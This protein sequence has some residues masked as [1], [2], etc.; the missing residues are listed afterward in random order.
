MKL[1]LALLAS[2]AL[3]SAALAAPL[4]LSPVP[5][6]VMRQDGVAADTVLSEELSQKP[7]VAGAA[8]LENPTA[9]LSH[10]GYAADG[11]LAPAAGDTQSKDHNVEASKTEPDKNTYL[12]LEG[13]AGPDASYNYGTRFLFQG[14]E[15][16]AMVDGKPQGYIT[17]IN[18]DAD[19]AHR[20]TLMAD[21]DTAGNPLVFLDGSTWN[22]FA[23]RLLFTGEE[24]EEGGVWQA[25]VS[26]PS[27][28]ESLTGIIGIGSYEGI[29]ADKDGNLW[30]VEDAG[31]KVGEVNKHAK[32]PNSFVYRF[33]PKDKADLLKGGKLEA[34][35]VMSQ[36]GAPIV[37]NEGKIDDHVMS[38]GMKDMF[39]YGVSLKTAWVTVHDT[40]KDGATP[41]DANK[42]AKAAMAAPMKRPENGV[43]RP[44]TDFAEFYF[45][46]T[47]D[48]NA[49]TEAKSD[50]G[51]FGGIFKLANG[52]LSM[53]YQGSAERTGFD[54]L[55]F[56]SADELLIVED[57]G[58]KLH[59]QRKFYDCGY[60]LDLTKDY[61]SGAEPLRFMALGRDQDATVDAALMSVKDSGFQN[62]GDNEITGIHVSDGDATPA[63]LLGAK[64][65][66]PFQN[67]WR[68]FYTQQ[69]GANQTFELTSSATM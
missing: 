2:I 66:T 53:V 35:Q 30:I 5:N 15:A 32:Q 62:S 17:R 47:G 52:Q 13:Q 21:K 39:T 36:A 68:V 16:G 65:P 34:L 37:F 11:P 12:V 6:P 40:D 63:G 25:T 44:G 4:K 61:A 31:G 1:R 51:G 64:V 57:A 28:V 60:V 10:Y 29:Q 45:T 22:P 24:G 19:E 43:F 50:H 23:Q 20:V 49:E 8:K 38:D 26:Y 9:I 46:Q 41:F 59:G 69:H 3:S 67:G 33:T 7:V 58:D 54:N 56:A 48:T 18:L 14:H 27:K 55:Q 42:L